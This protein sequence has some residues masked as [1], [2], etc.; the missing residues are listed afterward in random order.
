MNGSRGHRE[1]VSCFGGPSQS[2]GDVMQL[3]ANEERLLQHRSMKLFRLEKTFK[4]S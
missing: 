1:E 2:S 4:I 3:H